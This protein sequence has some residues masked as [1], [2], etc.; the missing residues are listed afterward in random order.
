MRRKKTGEPLSFAAKLLNVFIILLTL[1][2]I[3]T[4][5]GMISEL[6]H[7]YSRDR[8]GGI[9]YPMEDKEYGALVSYYYYQNYNVAPF[10]SE[11]GEYYEVAAYADA[12]FLH[13]YFEA[14]GDLGAAE[15]YRVRMDQARSRCGDYSVVTEDIDTILS[16][17]PKN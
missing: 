10:L 16:A 6:R 1:I 2:F 5:S 17:I 4:A 14:A 7:A 12:A 3:F 11:Y 9:Q 13:R 15:R 8:F